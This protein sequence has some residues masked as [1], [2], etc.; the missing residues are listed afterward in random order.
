MSRSTY[1]NLDQ[2][3]NYLSVATRQPW[4][5]QQPSVRPPIEA[6]ESTPPPAIDARS[7]ALLVSRTFLVPLCS[8]RPQSDNCIFLT[9]LD[10]LVSRRFNQKV[11]YVSYV[12]FQ[13]K[14]CC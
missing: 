3:C 6:S 5:Q 14:I 4:Q 11:S 9:Q 13:I 8:T 1:T 7:V 2:K 10:I 12:I